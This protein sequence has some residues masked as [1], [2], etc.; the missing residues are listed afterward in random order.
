VTIGVLITEWL[1]QLFTVPWLAGDGGGVGCSDETE[2][3]NLIWCVKNTGPG[4]DTAWFFLGTNLARNAGDIGV[5]VDTAYGACDLA[6]QIWW[7]CENG[8]ND[9][10]PISTNMVATVTE[11][12]TILRLSKIAGATDG[13]SLLAYS[14]GALSADWAAGGLQLA[15]VLNK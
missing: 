5:C 15:S 13:I 14:V 7:A 3:G 12:T 4:Y 6:M 9:A 8:W 11:F 1:G 10:L 2:L